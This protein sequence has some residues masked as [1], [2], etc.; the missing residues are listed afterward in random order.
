MVKLKNYSPETDILDNT[1]WYNKSDLKE[2]LN[3]NLQE[4]NK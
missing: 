3:D 1:M 4:L 2:I